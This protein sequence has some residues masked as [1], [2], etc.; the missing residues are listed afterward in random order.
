MKL[1]TK[2]IDKKLFKQY[3]KGSSLEDQK[4]VAKIFNP[5]GRGTWYILNSD[6]EDPDYLWAI[7]DLF[8]IEVGS[9]SRRELESIKVPP[10]NMGLERDM[11]FDEI[12]AKELYDGLRSGKIYRRGGKTS[13]VNEGVKFDKHKY[14]AI[15]GDYDKDGVANIDD[16]SPLDKSKTGKVEQV[17]LAK[18]F[19]QLLDIKKDLDKSM[20]SMIKKLEDKSPDYADIYARTKTPYSIVKKLIDKR[21][22]DAKRG[23]TDL[24]GTTVATEDYKSLMKFRERILNGEFGVVLEE[25]DMYESPKGGYRAYHYIIQD[26][27]YPIELQLKTKRMK[28]IN[29]ISHEFYKDGTL[30]TENLEKL[31]ALAVQADLGYKDAIDDFEKVMSNEKGVKNLLSTKKFSDG[32][33]LDYKEYIPP[34][35]VISVVL[36]DGREITNDYNKDRFLSGFYLSDAKL[37]SEVDDKQLSLFKRGGKMPE[38]SIYIPRRDVDY[39]KVGFFDDEVDRTVSSDYI[40]NGVW[41]EDVK[42]KNMLKN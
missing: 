26:G 8:D 7:V 4:V 9:V 22:V 23:L 34:Y 6:P 41:I 30:N 29:E 13:I 19:K 36:K 25:E 40:M 14:E 32:G 10:F 35:E 1:F 12:N 33:K 15:F 31:T 24:V 20:N 2:S 28:E 17:E 18:S 39:I 11:Y 27:A 16:V 21:L 42:T 37:P 38:R 5:Y 3:S